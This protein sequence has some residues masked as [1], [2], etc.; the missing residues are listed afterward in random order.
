M[1]GKLTGLWTRNNGLVWREGGVVSGER[2][3]WTDSKLTG[4][5]RI[6]NTSWGW[7][8]NLDFKRGGKVMAFGTIPGENENEI[9]K[10]RVD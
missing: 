4:T 5:E 8:V 7:K 2:S 6:G 3:R 9:M 10:L 1:D